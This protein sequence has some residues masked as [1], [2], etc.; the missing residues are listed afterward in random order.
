MVCCTRGVFLM[1][2]CSLNAKKPTVIGL[3]CHKE[4]SAEIG[5]KWFVTDFCPSFIANIIN[6]SSLSFQKT[7]EIIF[8]LN[9]CVYGINHLKMTSSWNTSS[10]C[11]LIV[12][13]ICV[14]VDIAWERVKDLVN[15]RHLP[16]KWWKLGIC[17]SNCH[18][19]NLSTQQVVIS[20]VLYILASELIPN[21]FWMHFNFAILFSSDHM[22]LFRRL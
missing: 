17:V 2:V 7:A 3:K 13:C 12:V 9:L 11:L 8:S 10:S 15:N 1:C 21:N 5:L 4:V 6:T 20:H 14:K 22:D 18:L 16:L 19:Q